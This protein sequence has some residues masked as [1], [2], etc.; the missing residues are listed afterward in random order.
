MAGHHACVGSLVGFQFKD[1]SE[2]FADGEVIG[3][4]SGSTVTYQLVKSYVFGSLSYQREIY[5]PVSGAVKIFADGQ[6]VAAAIDYTTGQVEL[7]ATS[8]TEITKEGKFDV[9]VPFE[10]DVS[11]SIDNRHRVC[12]GSAELMEIRL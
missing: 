3:Y 1:A 6:E 8:D 2:F 7:S 5:K 11:F 9:P 12:S 10:D 4:G